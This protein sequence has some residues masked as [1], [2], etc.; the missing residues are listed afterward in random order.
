[1]RHTKG[2]R[3]AMGQAPSYK[4]GRQFKKSQNLRELNEGTW[5][6]HK[7]LKEK[8][9]EDQ[10]VNFTKIHA[11]VPIHRFLRALVIM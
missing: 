5:M 6:I 7:R 11:S 1:M 2:G 8:V 4:Q 10:F 9:L 3:V